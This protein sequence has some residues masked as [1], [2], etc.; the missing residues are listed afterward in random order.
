MLQEE[1][2][3]IYNN[4]INCFNN[5]WFFCV[6]FFYFNL[7]RFGHDLYNNVENRVKLL[8]GL[9][10][11]DGYIGKNGCVQYTTV[12][13]ELCYNIIKYN[14]TKYIKTGTE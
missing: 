8:Q 4:V 11:T 6:W 10:D 13:E 12:S 7:F 3:K 14:C 5:G 9:M 1:R 2:L